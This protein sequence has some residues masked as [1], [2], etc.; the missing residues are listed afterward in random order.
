MLKKIL[1]HVVRICLLQFRRSSRVKSAPQ[2][3]IKNTILWVQGHSRSSM[4]SLKLVTTACYDISSML[5][6]CN[7]FHAK[8]ANSG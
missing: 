8:Q 5:P 4:L 2:P 1:T 6:N 3:K 7:C